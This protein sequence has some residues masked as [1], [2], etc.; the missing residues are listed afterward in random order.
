MNTREGLEQLQVNI[1]AIEAVLEE[2]PVDG[3]VLERIGLESQRDEFAAQIT[4]LRHQAGAQVVQ[5]AEV[6]LMF[7]GKPVLGDHS[8]DAKFAADRLGDYQDLIASIHADRMSAYKSKRV[9]PLRDVTRLTITGIAHGC[10]GFRLEEVYSSLPGTGAGISDDIAI[11]NGL[12]E[13]A[14]RSEED[15][16]DAASTISDQVL[17][18]LKKFCNELDREKATLRIEAAKQR[19]DLN[20]ARVENA[21]KTTARTTI[22]HEDA[23]MR[24]IGSSINQNVNGSV[25]LGFRHLRDTRIDK[26]VTQVSPSLSEAELNALGKTFRKALTLDVNIAKA[27]ALGKTKE[28]YAYR[29]HT[30][31]PFNR[32]FD[33]LEQLESRFPIETGKESAPAM[34]SAFS[35]ARGILERLW[36]FDLDKIESIQLDADDGVGIYVG[37]PA[38]RYLVILCDL[39]GCVGVL[40]AKPDGTSE[41]WD[42]PSDRRDSDALEAHFQRMTD[43]LKGDR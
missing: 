35:S 7:G 16:L 43:F 26:S 6:S 37:N 1:K 34:A 17:A 15:F 30:L 13:G 31:S 22:S 32:W 18:K 24:V 39:E 8:I 41:S 28:S 2:L 23:A 33:R 14:A 38:G 19:V 9:P 11:L 27:T 29:Q 36:L 5:R 42:L 40:C 10:F 25:S 3:N 20:R 12:L 4:T 21:R